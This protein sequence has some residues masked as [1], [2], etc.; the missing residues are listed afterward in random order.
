MRHINIC[1]ILSILIALLLVNNVSAITAAVQPARMVVNMQVG[2][3]IEN[4]SAQEKNWQKSD[5]IRKQITDK[6]Y[7]IEDTGNGFKVKKVAF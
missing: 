5:E 7:E 3:K 2:E 4:K 1:I 6:G